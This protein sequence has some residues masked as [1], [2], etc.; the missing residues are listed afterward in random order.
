[1]ALI[2]YSRHVPACVERLA[3]LFST[4]NK[5]DR[6]RSGK[7]P[8]LDTQLHHGAMRELTLIL[9]SRSAS[10]NG[11]NSAA[12]TDRQRPVLRRQKRHARSFSVAAAGSEPRRSPEAQAGNQGREAFELMVAASRSKFLAIAHAI[13]RNREDAEDAVQNALFSGYLNL[14]NFEG[15]SALKTWFT[16][17]VMNAALMIRRKQRSAGMRTHAEAC[18]SDD[19]K[20]MDRIPTSQAD[21]ET[22]YAEHE[23]VQFIHQA[24]RK[25]KPALR[26]ALT[27]IYYDE[28]S[29]PEA[30]TVLGVTT[31][32]F[33]SR[34]RRARR[35][36]LTRA[37]GMRVAPIRTAT[38]SF[39]HKDRV[40]PLATGHAEI[41]SLEV[42]LS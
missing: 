37:R 16:R 28:M 22:V 14:P 15:R 24:L 8:A 40:Q 29:G 27:M 1:M 6:E 4:E 26:Q 25:M 35:Q 33:K 41:K 5:K 13:L 30:S 18:A 20:R 23:T 31:A 42:S 17:I 9:T 7:H 19:A 3:C 21:P 12:E 38:K 11:R 2:D 39:A 32:T 34:L 36:L 10:F